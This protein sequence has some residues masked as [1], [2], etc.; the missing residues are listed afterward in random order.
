[1][2][3]KFKDLLID[4]LNIEY[5]TAALV[6]Q[7]ARIGSQNGQ[8]FGS[9]HTTLF[10]ILVVPSEVKVYPSEGHVYEGQEQTH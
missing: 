6:D 10:P 7:N 5:K 4:I 2:P 3:H 1:M 8:W 9:D